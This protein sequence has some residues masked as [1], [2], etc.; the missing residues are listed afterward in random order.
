MT[1][2]RVAGGVWCVVVLGLASLGSPACSSQSGT[3]QPACTD[4]GSV[5]ASPGARQAV[6]SIL[7]KASTN[8]AEIDVV[9][10]DDGSAE[11]TLGVTRQGG[12]TD[13]DP[14]PKSYPP[15]SLEVLLFLCNLRA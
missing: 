1:L 13:F 11:R 15:G 3:S 6:A 12:T 7:V 8:S 4:V 2:D 9:V 5:D 14:A 10:F